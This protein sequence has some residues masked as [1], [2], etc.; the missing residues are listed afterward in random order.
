MS[1]PAT[2][3]EQL[4]LAV[5][6]VQRGCIVSGVGRSPLGVVALCLQHPSSCRWAYNNK[7]T[8]STPVTTPLE[9]A[10]PQCFQLELSLM[11]CDYVSNEDEGSASTIRG[12]LPTGAEIEIPSG[13]AMNQLRHVSQAYTQSA[14]IFIGNIITLL[15]MQMHLQVA[16]L[17]LHGG[18]Q[19]YA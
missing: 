8:G 16:R 5:T 6:R 2:T 1:S 4:A 3:T 14:R 18:L 7:G 15:I 19:H 17:K 12:G 11:R 10:W 9:F 13:V